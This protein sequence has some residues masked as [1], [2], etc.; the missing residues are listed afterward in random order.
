MKHK[1]Y[2]LP[3]VIASVFILGCNP[4]GATNPEPEPELQ[5]NDAGAWNPPPPDVTPPTV[6]LTH[7][8][9]TCLSG[10]VTFRFKA[11]D[12]AS[13][14]GFVSLTFAG[15]IL[16]LTDLGNDEYEASTD[17]SSLF[18]GTHT[19]LI[20]A[21]DLPNNEGRLERV[22]GVSQGG[23]VLFEEEMLCDGPIDEPEPSDPIVGVD[24]GP[25]IYAPELSFIEPEAGELIGA[26][27]RIQVK[28]VDHT[29]PIAFELSIGTQTLE[30]S[31]PNGFQIFEPNLVNETE[32]TVTLSLKG[33]DPLDNTATISIDVSLDL[34]PP[35]VRI[36]EPNAGD[37][38][39][40]LTDVKA[41][42]KDESGI[43]LVMLY[44]EGTATALATNNSPLVRTDGSVG[45]CNED[46]SEYGLFYDLRGTSPLPR[47]TTFTVSANDTA[48]N[49]GSSQINLRILP[50]N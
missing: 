42:V 7:P 16:T 6:T 27:P 25:D 13:P 29:M 4:T 12:D 44:E 10:E 8:A 1:I 47:N 33:T 23:G 41:C 43:A 40:A 50:I 20:K 21:F 39:L 28:A 19:L 18:E 24:A 35:T 5:M 11:E 17:V 48:G 3:L 15:Q 22:F 45:P 2:K 26:T 32:G 46:E 31:S 38:R 49:T 14:I 9:T 34:T 36:V 37:D 30:A